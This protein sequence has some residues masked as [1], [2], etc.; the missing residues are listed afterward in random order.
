LPNTG[1]RELIVSNIKSI[2][3]GLA[4]QLRIR[5]QTTL[6]DHTAP[7]FPAVDILVNHNNSIVNSIVETAYL[8][9]LATTN[10]PTPVMSRPDEFTISN[11]QILN[12]EVRINY[13][14]RLFVDF[15][16]SAAVTKNFR[17][18]FPNHRYNTGK[19]STANEAAAV[20]N[21]LLNDPLVCMINNVRFYCAQTY[22]PLVITINSAV[23]KTGHNRL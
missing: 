11:P 20:A 1:D 23:L 12:E 3:S 16:S 13:I 10:T 5:L 7:I 2:N 9:P 4:Y 17:I 8:V 14:G 21:S 15:D 18:A 19:W 22:N 6:A